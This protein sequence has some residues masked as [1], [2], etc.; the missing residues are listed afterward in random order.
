MKLT[1]KDLTADLRANDDDAVEKTGH[2]QCMDTDILPAAAKGEVDQNE[3]AADLVASRGIG[4]DGYWVGF[5]EAER[6]MAEL[7]ERRQG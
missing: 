7:R 3:V 6:Q 1:T 2:M 5:P 4:R